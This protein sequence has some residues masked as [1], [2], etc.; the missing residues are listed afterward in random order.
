MLCSA[1][2][3]FLL[4]AGD[5]HVDADR[6][7][8]LL[9]ALHTDGGGMHNRF[10]GTNSDVLS[11]IVSANSPIIALRPNSKFLGTL[12][13]VFLVN[14]FRSD[15]RSKLCHRLLN[16]PYFTGLDVVEALILSLL[17]GGF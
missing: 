10:K 6:L 7:E 13:F 5:K 12:F 17:E 2:L 15:W 16:E 8:T 3:I 9:K 1:K 4:I 11:L 14:I